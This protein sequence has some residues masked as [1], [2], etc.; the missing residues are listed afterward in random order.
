MTTLKKLFFFRGRE[1]FNY[2]CKNCLQLIF[3]KMSILKKKMLLNTFFIKD[4]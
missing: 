4:F 2:V 3:Y 1:Q